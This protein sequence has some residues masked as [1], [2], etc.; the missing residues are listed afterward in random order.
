MLRSRFLAGAALPCLLL[1]VPAGAQMQDGTA[2]SARTHEAQ[3]DTIP[4]WT[5][6]TIVVT[7]VRERYAA[8]DSSS[9]SRT[10]TP[11][12]QTPQSVQVLNRTLIEEQDRRTLAD[13]LVN[14]SGVTPTRPEEA[15]F[16]QPVVRGFPAEIYLDGLPAFGTTAF[17]D[18][19]SLVGTERIEV[20]KG[21]TSTVYGGGAGA[22][23]GGLI[24]VVSKRP[25]DTLGGFVAFRAGSFSTVNPYADLNV[26]L[27]SRFAARVTGEYQSNKSWIDQV[28]GDRWSVQPSIL[29][30]IGPRT[31]LLVRGQYDRRS[32]VE[33][34]GLPAAQALAG[35]IERDAFPGTTTGQ[36]RTTT[37]N[38]LATAELRHAF[39]D[40][41]R[42]TVTGHYYDS[43]I[44]GYG[45][46]VSP[47]FA[48]PDP[49]TPTVY[50]IFTLYLP[51]RVKE[52]T[53]DA[54]LSATID[55]LGGRHEL[56]GGI[57]Y[58]HTSFDSAIG[59]DGMPMGELDLARPTYTLTYGA[60]PT[61]IQT[62]TNRYESIAAYVQDQATCGR[63]HLSGS[64]R[65]T[66]LKL[67][68]QEQRYD[69][70][71]HRVIPRI[72]ATFDIT[73]G[74][75]LFAGYATGFRGAINFVGVQPPKP[76]TSRSFEGGLKL[77]LTQVGLS[78]TIAAF[79]LKRRNVT[80]ADPNNPFFSIQT[81]EQ[82]ARG[83]EA[84]LT[85]E[86]TPAFSLL[87]NYAYTD[88]EV[89]QDTAI[90]IGDRLPRVPR[91]SGRV[92][93][94]YRVLNGPVKGLSFG[95]GVTAFSSREITLPN[96]VSVPGYAVMDA[97]A[98]YDFDRFTIAV[99]TV[100]LGGRKAFDTYQYLALPVVIPTQ[101][102]S[103][104]VTLK[105]RF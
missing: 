98:A 63:L 19:T 7:G 10:N 41:V 51:T 97:Q 100:N 86:P 15:L 9:A 59:F 50:P 91:H 47:D 65:Y 92:A 83:V 96:S 48:G 75:A 103:A 66:Q 80:T 95:A 101:P 44:R 26:L 69:R 49:A 12:I 17:I 16:T 71:Y 104:Y 27:G 62:Q 68:Q 60:L 64:L 37:E 30:Q 99:S 81:G 6:D 32:Q 4:S 88:A 1:A 58:D 22:P 82:R 52:G 21:P 13:A 76:E 38:R 39:S 61:L 55:T 23:L 84:D 74:V 34:S 45:S 24:N 43:R 3:P 89:T 40:D 20:V 31:E 5:G 2:P 57:N 53:L 11:L 25:E 87:A 79:E 18:P 33:Y 29:A 94:R 42:L 102:R 14:V 90:P 28:K 93:A 46:F 72:G 8:P 73:K 54:N 56:L 35:Q 78:G 70:T 77:A 36:P 105:A 85:W 67:R